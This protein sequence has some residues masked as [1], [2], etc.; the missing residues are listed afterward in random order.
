MKILSAIRGNSK[1]VIIGPAIE[2]GQ[3]RK[4]AYLQQLYTLYEVK[5]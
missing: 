4:V 2:R 1:S 5:L 3:D